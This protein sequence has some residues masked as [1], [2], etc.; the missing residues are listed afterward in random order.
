MAF[1]RSAPT[2]HRAAISSAYDSA[3]K[4]NRGF[5]LVEVTVAMILV[6]IFAV[7]SFQETTQQVQIAAEEKLIGALARSVVI[8]TRRPGNFLRTRAHWGRRWSP[9]SWTSSG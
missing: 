4:P 9:R 5:I 6:A 7:V 2:R 3:S 1:A 8:T